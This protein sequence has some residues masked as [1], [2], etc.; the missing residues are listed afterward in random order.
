MDIRLSPPPDDLLDELRIAPDPELG[1]RSNVCAAS[2]RHQRL[3][4][5]AWVMPRLLDGGFDMRGAL[6]LYERSGRSQL[7]D[8]PGRLTVAGIY[9]E[10]LTL[11][12]RTPLT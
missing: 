12:N 4:V 11:I 3:L 8:A 1:D 6:D 10:V 9:A 2:K 7:L 5:A